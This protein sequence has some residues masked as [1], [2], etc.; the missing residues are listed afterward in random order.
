MKNY[1]IVGDQL[2]IFQTNS[3]INIDQNYKRN[4]K[5]ENFFWIPTLNILTDN[6]PVT[7]AG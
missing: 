1:S 5:K 2:M 6:L 4:Q 3:F 7:V